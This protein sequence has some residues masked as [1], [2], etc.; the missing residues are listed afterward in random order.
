[1]APNEKRSDLLKALEGSFRRFDEPCTP[2]LD[3][4]DTADRASMMLLAEISDDW[5]LS[6]G[7]VIALLGSMPIP[8]L[9]VEQRE[10]ILELSR[11]HYYL[12]ILYEPGMC[13]E[14]IRRRMPLFDGRSLIESAIIDSTAVR[15]AMGR[16]LALINGDFS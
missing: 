13:R 7:E 3:L 11:L 4:D 9:S 10:R 5:R 15:Y 8:P 12:G 2:V 1:M 6:N 16:V 14:W